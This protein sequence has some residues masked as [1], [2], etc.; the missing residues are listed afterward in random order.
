MPPDIDMQSADYLY[1]ILLPGR[2]LHIINMP[3]LTTINF[4]ELLRMADFI[5]NYKV[6]EIVFQYWTNR[7]DKLTSHITQMVNRYASGQAGWTCLNNF[8]WD[9]YTTNHNFVHKSIK[10]LKRPNQRTSNKEVSEALE[11]LHIIDSNTYD[12]DEDWQE[13]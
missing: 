9:R 3:L 13:Q 6:I 11:A 2:T 4:Q 7:S 10:A 12:E 1:C 8:I 5:N